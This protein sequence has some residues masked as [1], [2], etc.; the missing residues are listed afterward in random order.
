MAHDKKQVKPYGAPRIWE[1]MAGPLVV[2]PAIIGGG[3]LLWALVKKLLL[4]GGLI[5]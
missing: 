4:M 1:S 3:L 5:G 2:V